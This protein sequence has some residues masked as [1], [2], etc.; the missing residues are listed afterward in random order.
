MYYVAVA[1]LL[2]TKLCHLLC[3]RGYITCI[4]SLIPNHQV[5]I[6]KWTLDIVKTETDDN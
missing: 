4:T 3:R 6:T 5:M 1:I 2:I